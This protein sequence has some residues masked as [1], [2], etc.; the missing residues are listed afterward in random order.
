MQNVHALPSNENSENTK[1]ASLTERLVDAI[2]AGTI[3]PGSKISEPELAKRYQVSR[4]PLREAIMRLEGLGLIE[5]TPH[6]GATVVE[7]NV[8]RLIE[9]YD[10][11]ESL[12]GMAAR[13]AAT[14]ITA[15][16]L[17]AL[18]ALIEQ[19]SAYLNQSAATSKTYAA[20]EGDYDFHY[21]IIQASGN[22]KLISLLCDE[23]Y[24]LIRMYRH[25]SRTARTDPATAL[26]EHRFI[27]EAI[28]NRDPELAEMLM[29]RHI[30][31]SR[32]LI[33]KQL[34]PTA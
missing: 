13:L 21:Q 32:K 22:Q 5:R 28:R 6:V 16:Q 4:G 33:E 8:D 20:Q 27:L 14:H 18:E 12:E 15:D 3:R 31:G 30:S 7:F 2:V 11:R 23:L 10:V 25:Q 1:S 34:R 24:H 26:Q 9:L 19:H 17:S 29:R